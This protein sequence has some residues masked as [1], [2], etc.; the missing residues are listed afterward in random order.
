MSSALRAT[1]IGIFGALWLSGCAWLVL[2]FF[3][4]QRSDFGP[5]ESPWSPTLLRVHGWIAVVSVFLLG[6]VTA[7]HVSDRFFQAQRRVSGLSMVTLAVILA[8]TGYGLYYTTGHLH[9]V[10]AIVHE[11]IGGLAV[12]FAL[13]HWTRRRTANVH[14]RFT[15]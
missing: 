11:T 9:G 15:A 1:V 7:R 14:A 3:F 6:W 10:A 2:H 4:S 13:V 5:V 8:L 12:L